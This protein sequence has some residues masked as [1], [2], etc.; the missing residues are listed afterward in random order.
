MKTVYVIEVQPF[1]GYLKSSKKMS[2]GRMKI[3][4]TSDVTKAFRHPSLSDAVSTAKT[5]NYFVKTQRFTGTSINIP[6]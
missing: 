3:Q 4:F 5:M 1:N 2:D 6:K